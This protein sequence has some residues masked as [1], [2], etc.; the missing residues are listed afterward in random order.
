MLCVSHETVIVGKRKC[1]ELLMVG[2]A[3]GLSWR[4]LAQQRAGSALII[5]PAEPIKCIIK[6]TAA[7]KPHR[8]IAKTEKRN[9]KL[10]M[11]QNLD[12]IVTDFHSWCSKLSNP[13]D[14]YFSP[15]CQKVSQSCVPNVH[16][17]HFYLFY[18][19][20]SIYEWKNGANSTV[21]FQTDLHFHTQLLSSL[22]LLVL[23]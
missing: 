11:T 16:S 13:Y 2:G 12:A 4:A 10:Q 18:L 20:L 5:S 21:G 19:L 7:F 6:Q 8:W 9:T 15:Y 22:Q 17:K 23:I 1:P 14:A 3:V